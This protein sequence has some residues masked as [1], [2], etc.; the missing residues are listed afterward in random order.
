DMALAD[1]SRA[2]SERDGGAIE[3]SQSRIRELRDKKAFLLTEARYHVDGFESNGH[4]LQLDFTGALHALDPG[5][6][7]LSYNVG[8]EQTD[9]FAMRP[10]GALQAITI[11]ISEDTFRREIE[12]MNDLLLGARPDVPVG[13]LRLA[14][15]NQ[16]A[17]QLYSQLIRPVETAIQVSDRVMILPDGPLHSVPWGLLVRPTPGTDQREQRLVEWKPFHI[18][19][20]ASLFAELKM[21]RASKPPDEGP[22]ILA[23]GDPAYSSTSGFINELSV[24]RATR[25]LGL[26]PLP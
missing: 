20:S 19:L 26:I 15:L 25:D 11:P 2:I 22:S 24:K 23:F 21:R 16:I 1:L 9:L 14:H 12:Q 17:R 13:A 8:P 4:H 7:L 3:D 5:T 10:G 6:I 18:A